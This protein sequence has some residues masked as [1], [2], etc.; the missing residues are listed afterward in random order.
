MQKK[1]LKICKYSIFIIQ[2]IYILYNINLIFLFF[3]VYLWHTHSHFHNNS[4]INENSW[5]MEVLGGFLKHLF[6]LID[7]IQIFWYNIYN[8][9]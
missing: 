5:T 2:Y 9:I 7:D 8:I 4:S 3:S 1:Q 6:D